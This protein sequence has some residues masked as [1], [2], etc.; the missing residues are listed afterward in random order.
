MHL[1]KALPLLCIPL[2]LAS[3]QAVADYKL[4]IAYNDLQ[5][6]LNSATPTGLGVKATIVEASIVPSTDTTF[7]VFA[8]DPNISNFS[9]KNHSFPGLSCATPPCIPTVF[10]G[11]ATGTANIFYG[12][13]SSVAHGIS[14]IH[15]YEANQ[16]F[17]SLYV[18]GPAGQILTATT[19]DR[20]IANHSWIGNGNTP[21][22]TA[23]ILSLVDRQ[24]VRNEYIQVA[25]T[26]T[27]LLG[28]AYNVVA[29]GLTN[30]SNFGSGAVDSTYV[31]GRTRPDIVAPAANRSSATPIVAASAAVLIETGHQGGAT[32]SN[33]S[34]SIVANNGSSFTVYNAERSET[35]K[36]ALMA[37]ADKQTSNSTGFG[38][39]SDYRS[40]TNQ[41]DNGL[42]FR[43]GAGQ[44]NIFNSY[45]IIASGEQ[46]SLEDGGGNN[47]Q[48]G[49]SGFDYDDSFGGLKGSNSSASYAFTANKNEILSA[50]LVWNIDISNNATLSSTIHHL[51]L[52]LLDITDN[53][54]IANSSSLLDNT[55]NIYTDQLIGGHNYQ[56]VADTLE[57]NLF[58]WDYAL[59][60]NR[61]IST[62]PVPLP[63][64]FWLF[65]FA[66]VGLSKFHRKQLYRIR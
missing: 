13:S 4:D 61:S 35:I 11:H 22:Q 2:V 42:D 60:W 23:L 26:H 62:S 28:N 7:P 5:T 25:A 17:N 58:N 37:G 1:K 20:R 12:N 51:Q 52:S 27:A 53:S 29:V 44:V 9:A 30:G 49:L 10:S 43:Y 63:A 41:S 21:G 24:V 39:I 55:Q 59:A 45:H 34:K 18:H 54:V 6:E 50:S 38:D 31:S 48:I 64:A 14:D 33:G 66:L 40:T 19:T 36:A 47:G 32:L 15:S 57:S 46:N 8:P 16:W 65:A 56:I 3:S